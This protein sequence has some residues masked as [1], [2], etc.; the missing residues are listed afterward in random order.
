MA[1]RPIQFDRASGALE[2]AN[3][4]ERTAALA[5]ATGAK[6]SSHFSHMGY[7]ACANL[8]RKTLPERDIAVKLNE[9]AVFEFP[10]GDGYW[11]KLLNRDYTYEDELELLFEDSADVDYTL[12]DCGANYG[13][14]SVLASSRPFG[15]H[16]AIAIEPSEQNYAKLTNNAR[17][18]GNRFETMKCAIGAGRGTARLSGTKHEA[19]SIAGDS[20][21]GEE[22][23]VIALDDLIR[24]QKVLPEGKYLVKLD[25][26]GVEIDAMKG[27]RR[28]MEADSVLLCEEH[29][30]DRKHTV[31]RYILEQT[32]L[33][34]TVFDRRTRRLE[35][36]N[37]LS[38][39][40]R[41]KVSTNIG[42]NVFGTA[43]A[44]WQDRI[45][46][47]NAKAARRVQ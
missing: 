3:A 4:W 2:G 14:W 9:D 17:V 8:L 23:P 12:L 21:N 29:G 47:L 26:E 33:K 41:I 6:I 7:I 39:L 34:L 45:D 37:E 27:G 38:I 19:F 36:V 10:Y 30:S 43:S 15:A 46:A 5:L 40:D 28:L 22:V 13:Y 24:D 1:Q 44:F 31:S 20:A 32:P 18:N 16:K 25:V 11:S 35:T 42:Y